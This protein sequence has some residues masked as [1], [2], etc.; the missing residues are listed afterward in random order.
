M[1]LTIVALQ[2]T[3]L[4]Q[5]VRFDIICVIITYLM[6]DMGFSIAELKKAH[7]VSEVGFD[8]ICVPFGVRRWDEIQNGV[9]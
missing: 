5:E 4:G 7:L 9:K 1:G 6:S 2:R 3:H 8:I